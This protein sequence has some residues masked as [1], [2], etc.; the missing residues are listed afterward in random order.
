MI[1]RQ[2]SAAK[3]MR[4]ASRL[5]GLLAREMFDG[6]LDERRFDLETSRHEHLRKQLPRRDMLWRRFEDIQHAFVGLRK[7]RRR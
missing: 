2:M 1:Q 5:G 4:M 6:D 3:Q 7:R